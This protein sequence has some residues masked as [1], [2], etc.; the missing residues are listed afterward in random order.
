[1]ESSSSCSRKGFVKNSTAPAFIALT[2]IWNVAV[3]RDE[4][5]GDGAVRGDELPLEFDSAEARQIDIEH[6]TGWLGRRFLPEELGGGG[7]RLNLEPDGA[8]EAAQRLA[9]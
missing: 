9:H 2:V 3:A 4:D 5:D 7:E 6:K 1:M 8:N